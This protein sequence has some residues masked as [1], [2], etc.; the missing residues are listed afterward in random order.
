M[1][2]ESYC[3][4][5]VAKLLKEK[6]FGDYMNHYIMRNNGDGTADIL[7]TCTHQMACA[8]LREKHNIF[9]RIG[10]NRYYKVYKYDVFSMDIDIEN[11]HSVFS[12]KSY[13]EAV[14]DALKYTLENL[15]SQEEDGYMVIN[16]FSTGSNLAWLEKQGKHKDYYTKQE[17]IDMGFSFTL[18]G[19]IVTPNEMMEDIKKYLAWHE[20]QS[21]QKP[22]FRE[23]YKNIAESE[24][25]KKTYEDMSV[26]DELEMTL[27][28]SEDAYLRSNLEKLIK[29]LKQQK[30]EINYDNR[31]KSE[32]L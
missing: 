18:N 31:R 26:L 13:E 12:F 28:V 19:D 3:S 11:E 14:E 8:W 23:R 20:K 30:G 15:I 21:E 5:K 4:F 10:Y 27:S 17:L 1:I 6:G 22:N 32:S 9:I 25:F 16:N 7:N 24:W 2:T 29:E